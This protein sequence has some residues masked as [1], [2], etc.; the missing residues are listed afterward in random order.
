MNPQS[1][2][3]ANQLWKYR[4]QIDDDARRWRSDAM[5][6]REREREIITQDKM[7]RAKPRTE[8]EL[9][10]DSSLTKRGYHLKLFE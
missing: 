6:E 2:E 7:R 1:V 10:V 3:S 8:S 5:S 9:R 4:I